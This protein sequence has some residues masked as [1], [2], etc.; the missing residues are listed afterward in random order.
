MANYN[1][2][3]DRRNYLNNKL[4]TVTQQRSDILH[5]IREINGNLLELRI[6]LSEINAE[7]ANIT[8]ELETINTLMENQPTDGIHRPRIDEN[9]DDEISTIIHDEEIENPFERPILRRSRAINR[10]DNNSPDY[11]PPSPIYAIN[12]PNNDSTDYVSP[13]YAINTQNSP[14]YPPDNNS[15]PFSPHSPD[16]DPPNNLYPDSI[17]DVDD[18]SDVGGGSRV[19]KVHKSSNG[20]RNAKKSYKMKRNTKKA[21]SNGKRKTKKSYKMKRNTKKRIRH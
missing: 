15:P 5:E 1:S 2:L 3:A 13:M 12:T 6:D 20:K 14:D 11:P 19:K 16:D 9:E 8:Y 7:R 17:I 10:P 18:D 21:Y 4:P